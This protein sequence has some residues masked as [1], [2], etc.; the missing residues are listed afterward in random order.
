ML[1]RRSLRRCLCLA[2]CPAEVHK[3]SR[4]VLVFVDGPL[5][6]II[7]NMPSRVAAVA[8]AV[9]SATILGAPA[10][11]TA[12]TDSPT[13]TLNN[14]MAFPKVSFGLQVYGDDTAQQYTTL[15]LQAG[16]RNFFSSVLAG[17]QQGFG[18]GL[19]ASSV[20]RKEV[21]LL[22]RAKRSFRT[23]VRGPAVV[24]INKHQRYTHALTQESRAQRVAGH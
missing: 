18:R 24:A 19:A 13:I 1:L 3:S 7:N 17:N 14:G 11:V 22:R 4:I 20:P 9:L 8:A 16:I 21:R 10:A 6:A 23:L 2:R 12:S 15:A 5:R